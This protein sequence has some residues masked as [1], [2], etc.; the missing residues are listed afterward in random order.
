MKVLYARNL[1]TDLTEEKL[2]EMFEEHGKVERVKKIKDYAFIHFAER[3]PAVQAMEAFHGKQ[4]GS[5]TLEVSLAKPPSDKKKKE[6]VL[7]NR[8]RRMMQ[9]IGR[10]GGM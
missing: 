5:S 3:D 1:T 6:E 4:F 7:R 9:T 2:K 8:E 10:G